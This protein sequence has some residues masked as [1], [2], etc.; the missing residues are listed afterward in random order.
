[1]MRNVLL[2]SLLCLNSCGAGSASHSVCYVF[3]WNALATCIP[4]PDPVNPKP[5]KYHITIEAQ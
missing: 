3:I 5:M 2:L 4:E 1:M